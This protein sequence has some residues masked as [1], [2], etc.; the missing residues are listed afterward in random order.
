MLNIT[1][2]KC[3][4]TLYKKLTIEED[5]KLH[6]TC[7]QCYYHEIVEVEH[8]YRTTEIEKLANAVID[9]WDKCKPLQVAYIDKDYEPEAVRRA[10]TVVSC[11]SQKQLA[12]V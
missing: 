1:C 3:G 10:R 5:N 6:Y 7:P 11:R 9:L 8:I 12:G 4:E 2:N